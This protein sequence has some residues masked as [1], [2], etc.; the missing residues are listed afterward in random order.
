M[1]VLRHGR[2]M[3][4][5]TS[6][7]PT[8]DTDTETA[9]AEID[10]AETATTSAADRATRR[11]STPLLSEMDREW[12]RLRR[13]PTTLAAIAA[14]PTT[15]LLREVIADAFSIDDIVDATQPAQ[16][17]PHEC[18]EILA[19]LIDLSTE[20][21]LAGRIVLQRILGGLISAAGKWRSLRS[22]AHPIDVIIGS[23]WIAIAS[24]DTSSRSGPVAL[25]LIAD[26]VWIGFRQARR[27]MSST[28]IPVPDNT[29]TSRPAPPHELDPMQA[30]A[31][32]LRAAT[33]A[34]VPGAELD[35][36]RTLCANGSPTR[37]A[38]DCSVTARTIRNRRDVAVHSIR[39]ALGPE[40]SDWTDPLVDAA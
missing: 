8:T 5:S 22:E 15:G 28:E 17:P 24:Y 39:C 4:Q 20:R 6:P 34:G 38:Q 25:A 40:W 27:R 23:A 11:R 29:L 26:A 21:E 16:R 18:S 37:V 31:G 19:Q 36:I 13:R 10:T 7:T 9:T 2:F 30:L 3:T 14:W 33:R 35:L 12:A 1:K 32:T